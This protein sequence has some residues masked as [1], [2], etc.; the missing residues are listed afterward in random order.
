MKSNSQDLCPVLMPDKSNCTIAEVRLKLY[1]NIDY[2]SATERRVSVG[3][4]TEFKYP[5]AGHENKP[6]KSSVWMRIVDS[7]NVQ[8]SE[9]VSVAVWYEQYVAGL[10]GKKQEVKV[11]S[12]EQEDTD[13]P[14]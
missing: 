5:S 8:D 13:L 11:E 10:F 6:D 4:I 12:I 7:Q 3:K 1:Q 14:F 9:W 2:K